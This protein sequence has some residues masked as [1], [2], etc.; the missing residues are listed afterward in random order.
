MPDRRQRGVTLVEVLVVIA[1]IAVLLVLLLP[2]VSAV[3]QAAMTVHTAN[4]IKQV[5]LAT[6]SYSGLHGGA[7][8][9]ASTNWRSVPPGTYSGYSAF[10]EL[11]PHLEAKG[12]GGAGSRS[13]SNKL[14]RL[15]FS[16][17]DPTPLSEAD[18]SLASLAA[19][20]LGYAKDRALPLSFPDGLSNTFAVGEHYARCGVWTFESLLPNMGMGFERRA[21]FADGV[22]QLHGFPYTLGDL[23]PVPFGVPP[24]WRS[25]RDGWTFQHRPALDKCDSTAAQGLHPGGMLVGMFDG[26]TRMVA[27]GI[28]QYVYW[29]LVT[30]NKGEVVGDW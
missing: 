22:G 4:Q 7:I 14:R 5:V 6:H 16:P 20:A 23:A 19:N 3:R 27:P 24:R 25:M 17:A 18:G 2:A 26:S 8:P 30:P 21:T 29:A 28:D 10:A 1:I 9:S 11:L 12:A 13:I 15:F